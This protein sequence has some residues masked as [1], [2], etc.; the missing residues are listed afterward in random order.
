MF[1]HMRS[2]HGSN[3]ENA[4]FKFKVIGKFTKPIQRQLFESKC[5]EN[6]PQTESL[7]SKDEFNYQAIRKLE[8]KNNDK[9][10][11]CNIC[12]QAFEHKQ[13]LKEHDEKFHRRNF[14]DLCDYISYGKTDLREH[15][16]A[17]EA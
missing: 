15:Q 17:H 1:K 16:K 2:E 3:V 10:V 5:I 7:N 12:G 14:C 9:N 11:H 13:L 4:D 8:L 6:T